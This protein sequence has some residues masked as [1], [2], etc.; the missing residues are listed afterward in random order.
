MKTEQYIHLIE[1][2]IKTVVNQFFFRPDN[3]FSEEEF[4]E[5][6]FAVFYRQKELAKVF[7]TS[8]GRKTMLVHPEY[9]SVNRISLENSKGYRRWYDIAI[10]NPEFIQNNTYK[11]VASRNENDAV[12]W[13][14][15]L[16]AAIEFKFLTK[17]VN[18]KIF[19]ILNNDILKLEQA[20]EIIGKYCLVFSNYKHFNKDWLNKFNPAKTKFLFEEVFES[21]KRKQRYIFMKPSNWLSV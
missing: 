21:N 16:I 9:P 17:E 10:L 6:L 13:G 15:N 2:C 7:T 12:L 8:D 19:N 18:E 20:K 5:Y 3:F 14:D 4:K 1:K 11:V